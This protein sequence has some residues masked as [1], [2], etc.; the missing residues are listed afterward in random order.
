ME[1]GRFQSDYLLKADEQIYCRK[2]VSLALSIHEIKVMG[3]GFRVG[4]GFM[5]IKMTILSDMNG[6]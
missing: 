4:R 1:N 5:N 2:G 6:E 3:G